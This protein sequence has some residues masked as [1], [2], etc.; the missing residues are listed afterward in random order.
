MFEMVD[1]DALS[2]I[3]I[4]HAFCRLV[5]TLLF[6]LIIPDISPQGSPSSQE[7]TNTFPILKLGIVI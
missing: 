6:S 3:L 1:W 5:L 4:I 2:D 7:Q